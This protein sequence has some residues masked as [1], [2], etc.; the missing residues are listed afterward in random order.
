MGKWMKKLQEECTQERIVAV[1]L[2]VLL[3]I[4]LIPML[5]ISKYNVMGVDDYRYLN[6]AKNALIEDEN[7]WK[8]FMTQMQNSYECW[9][10]W[11]GQYFVNFLIMFFLAMGGEECYFAV[12]FITLIPLLVAD[13]YLA[14][15][16]LRKG[17]GASV[18][19][20]CIAILPI[21][22][23]QVSLPASLVEAFYWLCGAVTYT[24]VYAMSLLSIGLL[25]NLMLS[26]SP[27]STSNTGVHSELEI[28][29]SRDEK[30]WKNGAVY[31]AIL[32]LSV[33]LGGGNLVTGLFLLLVFFTYTVY[34]F[35]KK[36]KH[37]I[38]CLVNTL[39]Y[40]ASFCTTILSPGLM[41]RRTENAEAQVSAFKAIMMSLYEAGKYIY[42]WTL[43]FVMVALIGLIPLF[44]K[45][46]QKRK[47]SFPA[48]IVVFTFTFGLYAAQFTPNQYALG[49][50]GAYR[51]QN[52][53]RF[54]MIFF[55]LLNE[56]YFL[57]YL[58]RKFPNL[59]SYFKKMRIKIP[60]GIVIYGM[61]FLGGC[62]LWMREIAGS[63]MSSTSAY[64]NLRDGSA[65][66]YYKEYQERLTVLEDETRKDVVFEP[67]SVHPYPL[68]F[69][70]F[71][72]AGNWV[73]MYAAEL[74]HKNTIS[75]HPM[76]SEGTK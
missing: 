19:Q 51:V 31:F 42:T 25:T 63:T 53:Y 67:Y 30:G 28:R 69:G 75:I 10:T 52:I 45:I 15:V 14:H 65:V 8:V 18:A 27:R 66:Q 11:Q 21:M 76:E 68:F 16:V 60:M 13:Y 40:T 43:P 62:F 24:T 55:L 7:V 12:P 29:T 49:I 36:N 22:I 38:F 72:E 9:R 2:T 58:H 23:Y 73:N 20:T 70:D 59:G 34:G 46:I 48:P 1:A 50:L 41:S 5:W 74:Y 33:C 32:L 3:V 17:F 54:Q 6:I 47:Y 64:D 56:F 35:W 4:L 37:R 57:G 71:Q 61:V 44:W 39:V 26:D